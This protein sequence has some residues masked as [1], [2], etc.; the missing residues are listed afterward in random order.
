MIHGVIAVVALV[1]VSNAIVHRASRGRVYGDPDLIP[2]NRVALLL[3]TTPYTLDGSRNQLFDE[4]IEAA[5]SLLSSG[6][7]EVV[8]ASGDNQRRTYN[9]PDYMRR[10]LLANGVSEDSDVLDYAGFRTL[11]SVGRAHEV[12]G[13]PE[14]TVVS[15][16]FHV[17]RA[18]FLAQR[19]DID[20]VGFAADEG[21]VP[22]M[23]LAREMLARCLAVV[24]VLLLNTRPRY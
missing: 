6:R 17:R 10:A 18:L 12:F 16:R 21:N 9:E 15:Q 14:F 23:I 2:H 24:D 3:G 1:V 5:A 7:V 8:L 20:A 13:Q 4:R 11:D 22:L 19:N